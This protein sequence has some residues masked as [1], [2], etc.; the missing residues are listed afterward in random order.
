MG[1]ALAKVLNFQY[2]LVPVEE[3]RTPIGQTLLILETSQRSFWEV[4][5][6]QGFP[7]DSMKHKVIHSKNALGFPIHTQD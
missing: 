3:P 4:Q 5:P 1:A 2:K 6:S 7:V